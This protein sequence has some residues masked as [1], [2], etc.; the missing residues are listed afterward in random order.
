MRS[1]PDPALPSRGPLHGHDPS[2]DGIGQAVPD[3]GQLS[4]LRRDRLGLNE[5]AQSLG[6]VGCGYGYVPAIDGTASPPLPPTLWR[7]GEP[8]VNDCPDTAAVVLG[9]QA[10]VFDHVLEVGGKCVGFCAARIR[11]RGI[12]RGRA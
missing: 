6:L 7:S 10:P 2:P 9:E 12:S 4:Q 3:G 5:A 11:D 8:A 1:S